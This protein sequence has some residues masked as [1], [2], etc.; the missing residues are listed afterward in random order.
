M[1]KQNLFVSSI[2]EE[3]SNF[4]ASC[5]ILPMSRST[6]LHYDKANIT[7][8]RVVYVSHSKLHDSVDRIRVQLFR[9]KTSDLLSVS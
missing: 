8:R 6:F 4:F 9:F 3:L 5:F 2:G 7:L 1:E